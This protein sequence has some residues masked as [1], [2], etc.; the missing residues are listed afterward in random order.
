MLTCH[1]YILLFV[2]AL[3]ACGPLLPSKKEP[4]EVVSPSSLLDAQVHTYTGLLNAHRHTAG[5]ILTDECDSTYLS[6]LIG[7]ALPGTVD[8]T[9]AR[10]DGNQ[11]YRR[12]DHNC[13][14]AFGN[15]RSTISRDMMLGVMWW[16]WRNKDLESANSLMKTLQNDKYVLKGEGSAGELVFI[17]SYTNTLAELVLALGGPRYEGEL[18]LPVIIDS[19]GTGFE[20]NLAVWHLLLRGE[21]MGGLPASDVET[22]KTHAIAQPKN[23]L[24]QAAYHK[25]LDGDMSSVV[26]LLLDSDEWPRDSLPTSKNHCDAW[27]VQR[28]WSEKDWGSCEPLVEHTGGELIVIYYLIMVDPASAN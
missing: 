12:P 27:P 17:P 16:M 7:A 24:Y 25:Y 20:R 23:P 9:Q 8:L 21:I 2:T 5:F 10:G 1:K 15:S 18:H 28:E 13:G 14:P 4:V 19:S 11:W 6:G 26:Q 3:L 22:L